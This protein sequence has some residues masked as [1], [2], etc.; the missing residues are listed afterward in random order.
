MSDW[1]ARLQERTQPL[2]PNDDQYGYAHA[3]L[4]ETMAQP[5]LQV[6]EL[7]D[8]PD[9]LP[10]W[11][12]LFSV[13]L[14]PTWALP[15]LAQLVGVRLPV[16]LSETDQRTFIRSVS[17]NATGTVASIAAAVNSTL[18]SSSPPD[19]PTVF[20]RERDGSAYR[21]EIVTQTSETPDPANTLRVVQAVVPAGIVV[22]VTQVV[23]W[24][25]QQLRTEGGTYA[26]L[27]TKYTTYENLSEHHQG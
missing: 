15:W 3:I 7:I 16:G 2:A 9:P 24:D 18:V 19:P 13:D 10:P 20:I 27:K 11:A 5:F 1:G 17:G 23:G 8:P 12:P 6:A 26:Q 14:C 25:Y 22:S 21:L 4:C